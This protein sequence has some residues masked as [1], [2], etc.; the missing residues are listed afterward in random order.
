MPDSRAKYRAAPVQP[1][2]PSG[3]ED[4][5][6]HTLRA[7][8]AKESQLPENHE[9]DQSSNTLGCPGHVIDTVDGVSYAEESCSME[10]ETERLVS[11]PGS[12]KCTYPGLNLDVFGTL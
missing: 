5:P 10:R 7:S 2:V 3:V 4:S 8:I 11:Q 12:S 6:D 9:F 1:G